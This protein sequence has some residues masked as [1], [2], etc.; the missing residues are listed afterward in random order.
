MYAQLDT[1]LG[2]AGDAQI[3]NPV[4]QGFGVFDIKA[5]DLG[6]AFGKHFV[7]L[8]RDAERD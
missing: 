2:F 8:Q 7:E 1:F 6:N 4:T 3:L 5:G